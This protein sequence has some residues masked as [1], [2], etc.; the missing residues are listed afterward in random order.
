[1]KI[2]KIGAIW[3]PECIIMKP[4]W[5]EIEKEIPNLNIEYIDLD[6][7]PEIKKEKNID[8]VPTFIFLDNQDNEV[9]RLKGLVEKDD[10]LEKINQLKNK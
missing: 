2:I 9:L 6:E 1:M 3:C 5:L 8:H 4:R 10:L 7:N